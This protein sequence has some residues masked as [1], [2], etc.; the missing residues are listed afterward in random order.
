MKCSLNPILTFTSSL[1]EK[2]LIS[3][4]NLKKQ[5][6]ITLDQG[7]IIPDARGLCGMLFKAPGRLI[8]KMT[9]SIG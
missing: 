8:I 3:N 5:K 4:L 9:K 2:S 1:K 7:D 6:L